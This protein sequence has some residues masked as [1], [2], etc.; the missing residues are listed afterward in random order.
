MSSHYLTTPVR[1]PFRVQVNM[2]AGKIPEK[3]HNVESIHPTQYQNIDKNP[4]IMN[5]NQN[6]D[7]KI[8]KPDYMGLNNPVS[9]RKNSNFAAEMKVK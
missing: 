6:L 8:Y 7:N 9:A 5:Q 2:L 1:T 3:N 4:Y